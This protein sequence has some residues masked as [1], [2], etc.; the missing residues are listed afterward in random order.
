MIEQKERARLGATLLAI[1]FALRFVGALLALASAYLRELEP[2]LWK[3]H[4]YTLLLMTS[5]TS[6]FAGWLHIRP[7]TPA[8]ARGLVSAALVLV[9]V[10]LALSALTFI[11]GLKIPLPGEAW[12]VLSASA[13]VVMW[14]AL[15]RLRAPS[16]TGTSST[17]IVVLVT[18]ALQFGCS[19][20]AMWLVRLR[21][22]SLI[23]IIDVATNLADLLVLGLMFGSA[24]ALLRPSA[25]PADP[26]APPS[27]PYAG[28]ANDLV[29]G[30]IWLVGGLAVTIG[31]YAVASGGSGGH[32]VVT[33]GAI[34]Y[35]MVRI[36]RGLSRR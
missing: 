36:I 15:A 34:A 12:E 25:Q 29:V 31:S 33:T 18:I 19:M 35:G 8:R 13:L 23:E 6:L 32:Y 7:S 21:S 4:G 5:S 26:L 20:A 30:S 3:S 16:S 9:G 22:Y 17:T 24:R 11:P 28:S 14:L 27:V 10:R 1:G 2:L